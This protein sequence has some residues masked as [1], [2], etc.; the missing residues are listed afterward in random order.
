MWRPRRE[1]LGRRRF[2]L[3]AG[4]EVQWELLDRGELHLVR[5]DIYHPSKSIDDRMVCRLRPV[6]RQLSMIE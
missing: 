1:H 2:G 5:Y 3:E 4:E 6:R